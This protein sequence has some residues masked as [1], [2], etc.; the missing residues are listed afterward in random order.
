R[1][2]VAA[3]PTLLELDEQRLHERLAVDLDPEAVRTLVDGYRDAR[4]ARGEPTDPS[5]LFFAIESD[6]VYGIPSLRIAEAQARHA[7]TYRSVLTWQSPDPRLRACH[8]I[9]LSFVF[10]TLGIEGMAEFA[11]AGEEA[12]SLAARLQA[13]WRTFLHGGSPWDE[14]DPAKR[15]T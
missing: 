3:D 1:L 6:R 12:E 8:T 15:P 11:G 5:E 14:F 10:G 9:D 4:A 7:V 2:A 13:A